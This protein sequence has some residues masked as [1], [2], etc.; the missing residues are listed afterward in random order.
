[1]NCQ[2]SMCT[3]ASDKIDLTCVFESC[4]NKRE[5]RSSWCKTNHIPFGDRMI[6]PKPNRIIK[7]IEDCNNPNFYGI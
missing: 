1:M 7:T 3:N 4:V 5:E 6:A 2:C